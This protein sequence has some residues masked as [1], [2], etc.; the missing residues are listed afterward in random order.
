MNIAYVRCM[1]G[2]TLVLSIAA[3]TRVSPDEHF[4]GTATLTWTPAKTDTSGNALQGLAGYRIHYGISPRA[5][6]TVVTVP[7]P[8]QT[9]Y[10]VKDL[11]PGTWYFAISEYTASGAE[12]ALSGVASKTIE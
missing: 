3:C 11:Y 10:V 2:V 4:S 6:Y 12:S 8:G 5:L 9:P 7:D 1:V